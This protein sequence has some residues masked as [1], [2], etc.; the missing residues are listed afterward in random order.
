MPISSCFRDIGR[1]AYWV[2]DLDLSRSGDVIGH[3][4]IIYSP[5]PFPICLFR[6]FFGKMHRLATMH[7]LQTTDRRQMDTTL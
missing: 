7:A 6:Q 2:R 5:M 3:V 4:T 1:Y